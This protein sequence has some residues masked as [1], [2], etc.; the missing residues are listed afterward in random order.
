MSIQPVFE[1]HTEASCVTIELPDSNIKN[2]FIE[3]GYA[4]GTGNH[5]T[6]KLCLRLIKKLSRDMKFKSVLDIGCGSG[7]L[8]IA[9]ALLFADRVI[10]I[11]IVPLTMKLNE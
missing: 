3:P 2:I 5:T 1:Y 9:S 8:T 6:T 11:D 4:F 10:A 7:I